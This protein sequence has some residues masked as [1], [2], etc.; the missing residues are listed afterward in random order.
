MTV[1]FK[2]KLFIILAFVLISFNAQS[3]LFQK[4]I[5]RANRALNDKVNSMADKLINK[6]LN[7]IENKINGNFVVVTKKINTKGNNNNTNYPKKSS[8]QN[9]N[10]DK[11]ELI[12]EDEKDYNIVTTQLNEK[13]PSFYKSYQELL[14]NSNK[15]KDVLFIVRDKHEWSSTIIDGNIYFDLYYFDETK[16][17]FSEGAKTW[18]LL[19][20]ISNLENSN[21]TNSNTPFEK[22]YTNFSY[23]LTKSK[24]YAEAGDCLT[25]TH[26]VTIWK[27]KPFTPQNSAV[28][29]QKDR[30]RN[31]LITE[32][33]FNTCEKIYKTKCSK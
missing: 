33:L 22:I 29:N 8:I 16:K 11:S 6:S 23:A 26:A 25:L 9:T 5:D 4:I 31:K 13:F 27:T 21:S 24:E 18:E 7:T 12:T 15:I 20:Q 2:G 1:K 30:A 14:S 3:Q 28:A 10:K 17:D 32:E 19:Y